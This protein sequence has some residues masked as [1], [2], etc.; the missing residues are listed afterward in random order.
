[1]NINVLFAPLD[2]SDGLD[3]LNG[4]PMRIH[5]FPIDGKS[6]GEHIQLYYAEHGIFAGEKA[7]LHLIA[8]TIPHPEDLLAL[9]SSQDADSLINKDGQLLATKP[10]KFDGH[11]VNHITARHQATPLQ[12]PWHIL[13]VNEWIQSNTPPSCESGKISPLADISGSISLGEGTRVLSGVV[14][15][16]NVSIGKDCKIGPNCYIRGNVSIGNNC[17]IGQS[18]EI[19]SS[20]IGHSSFVSHLSYIGDSIVGNHV[21][22]GAGTVCSNFRHDE[23][24]HFVMVDGALID[25]SRDKLGAMI[26]NHAKL[27]CHTIIYPG[28]M[29][30]ARQTTLPG[31]IVTRNLL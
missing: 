11:A 1:M 8:Q 7:D 28:R 30:Y 14:I 6:I 2:H 13:S 21:N 19:K 22:I 5:D 10:D 26:G 29:I 17:I 16:G 9:A 31:Q 3:F 27:G 4:S 12:Y 23:K 15:E 20:I 25:S 24:N 18:V